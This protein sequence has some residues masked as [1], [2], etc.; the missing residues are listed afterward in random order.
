MGCGGE[1]ESTRHDAMRF[2]AWNCRGFWATPTS[3][4]LHRLI[5][6][7]KS[8]VVFLAEILYPF[9]LTSRLFNFVGL[10]HIAGVDPQGRKGGFI[11]AWGKNLNLN[12]VDLFPN[13]IHVSFVNENKMLSFVTFV[14]GFPKTELRY[15]LWEYLRNVASSI[16]G[17]WMII[18]DFNQ[19][20]NV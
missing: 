14:Y 15:A 12:V 17:P 20:K 18:G 9:D 16:S 4:R 1:S 2:S 13:W 10:C 3:T 11:L 6:D 8:K 7:K 5:R 19:I